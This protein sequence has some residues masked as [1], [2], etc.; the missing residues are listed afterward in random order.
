MK[1]KKGVWRKINGYNVVLCMR[2]ER[3]GKGRKEKRREEKKKEE[4]RKVEKNRARK[5]RDRQW[6]R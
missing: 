2:E 1:P 3:E 5:R 6:R 4:K